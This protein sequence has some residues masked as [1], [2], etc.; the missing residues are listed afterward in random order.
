MSKRSGE[1]SYGIEYERLEDDNS[2]SFAEG[3]S[4]GDNSFS[5]PFSAPLMEDYVDVPMTREDYG[6]VERSSSASGSVGAVGLPEGGGGSSVKPSSLS[7]DD[8]ASALGSVGSF[9]S[10]SR[11]PTLEQSQPSKY[12]ME[13]RSVWAQMSY[14][15]GACPYQISCL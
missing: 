8:V 10:F 7:R 5:D 3:P 9:P 1:T 2:S 6:L 13:R 14:N 12:S 4:S 15:I 11:K